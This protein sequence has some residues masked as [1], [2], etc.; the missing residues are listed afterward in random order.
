M[1]F[2]KRDEVLAAVCKERDDLKKRLAAATEVWGG[3]KEEMEKEISRL[4]TIAEKQ[5][6][7]NQKACEL[8]LTLD[9]VAEDR[10]RLQIA[11]DNMAQDL[12]FTNNRLTDALNELARLRALQ[13]PSDNMVEVVR[14]GDCKHDCTTLCP[15]AYIEKQTLQFINHDADFFCAKGERK[16]DYDG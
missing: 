10:D 3:L 2:E 4:K 13:D 7:M 9:T 5:A 16:E 11:Y 1:C 8:A 14:C 6:E 12:E 15:L